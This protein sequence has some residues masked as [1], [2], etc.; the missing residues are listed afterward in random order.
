[1]GLDYEES[2]HAM[3]RALQ[4]PKLKVIALTGQWGTGKTYMLQHRILPQLKADS[5]SS[6]YVSLFGVRTIE[7]LKLKFFDAL[8]PVERRRH[9]DMAKS[10]FEAVRTLAEKKWPSIAAKLGA[11][12]MLLAGA[13]YLLHDTIV[14]LDDVERKHPT[15]E[16]REV[17]GFIEE[18]VESNGTR[19]VLMLNLARLADEAQWKELREKV[20]DAEVAMRPSPRWALEVATAER[21]NWPYYAAVER[22]VELIDLNNIRIMRR[23]VD[24]VDDIV[25]RMEVASDALQRRM[26]PSI[27]VLTAAYLSESEAIPRVEFVLA[28][29]SYE[30][31]PEDDTPIRRQEAAWR[32]LLHELG[33]LSVD[34]FEPLVADYLRNGQL[35]ESAWQAVK[36]EYLSGERFDVAKAKLSAFFEAAFWDGGLSR[37][38]IVQRAQTL[39]AD[40]DLMRP[41]EISAVAKVASNNGNDGVAAEIISRWIAHFDAMTPP[42]D[43]SEPFGPIGDPIDPRVDAAVRRWT[44]LREPPPTLAAAT[45]H[46][47]DRN[48]FGQ[49]QLA[50]FGAA[51]A[52]SY[53]ATLK[54]LSPADLRSFVVKHLEF[55]GRGDLPEE[56]KTAIRAFVQGC[57]LVISASDPTSRL[58]DILDRELKRNHALVAPHR[59]RS[60]E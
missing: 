54:S 22:A 30:H 49:A 55:L 33:I 1:M 19:F 27:V 50:A 14:F 13:G 56:L 4:N 43:F 11:R 7:D 60:S 36:T 10:A 40:V 57:E 23:I 20:I 28:L 46:A 9:I 58:R 12:P 59:T 44:Q 8:V 15:L 42:P 37:E 2:A 35:R 52:E 39:A 17:L 41:R 21:P 26:I 5:K 31:Y 29:D 18:N 24:A 45:A 51:S 38:E 6:L 3:S 25:G 53:A 47:Y 34:Q 48:S 16:T 32:G